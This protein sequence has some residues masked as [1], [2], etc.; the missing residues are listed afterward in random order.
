MPLTKSCSPDSKHKSLPQTGNRLLRPYAFAALT[1]AHR[2]RCAAA[3]FLRAEADRVR[4]IGA[5]PVVFAAPAP[6]FDP[7]F[8]FAHL[9]F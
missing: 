7:A 4:L 1:F 5:E 2:A 3:I 8:T 9:A 6:G